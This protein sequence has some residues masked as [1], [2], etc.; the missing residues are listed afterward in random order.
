MFWARISASRSILS[1]MPES[2]M[3]ALPDYQTLLKTAYDDRPDWK[4]FNC[5]KNLAEENLS[6]ARTATGRPSA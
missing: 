5:S 4:S 6:L 1:S 2:V 3:P